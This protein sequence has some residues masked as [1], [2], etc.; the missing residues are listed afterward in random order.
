MVTKGQ[1]GCEA[2]GLMDLLQTLP[3]E[4]RII[5]PGMWE[6]GHFD[7]K[8]DERMGQLLLLHEGVDLFRVRESLGASGFTADNILYVLLDKVGLHQVS[9]IHIVAA[10]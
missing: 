4:L 6:L 8:D 5:M 1:V 7:M 2:M 3:D 10:V 9:P